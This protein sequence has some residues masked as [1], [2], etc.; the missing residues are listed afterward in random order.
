MSLDGIL[1]NS[2][3]CVG[4]SVGVFTVENF[5]E[6]LISLDGILEDSRSFFGDPLEVFTVKNSNELLIS[7]D[8]SCLVDFVAPGFLIAVT[9]F[10]AV[11]TFRSFVA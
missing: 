11:A 7:F 1:E 9:D 5:D 8:E 10:I 6:L 3:S 2:R 4:D